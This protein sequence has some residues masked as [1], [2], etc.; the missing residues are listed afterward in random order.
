MNRKTRK[1]RRIDNAN[2]VRAMYPDLWR[3]FAHLPLNRRRGGRIGAVRTEARL[4]RVSGLRP[5]VPMELRAFD[6]PGDPAYAHYLDPPFLAPEQRPVTI[7]DLP[8][9][10][11][12]PKRAM[13][14]ALQ[15]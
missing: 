1:A 10:D 2:R 12:E 6:P 5:P 4:R 14:E 13:L 3:E 7:A 8:P 11:D 9:L 15:D